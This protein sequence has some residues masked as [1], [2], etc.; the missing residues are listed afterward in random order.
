MEGIGGKKDC[1]W[2]ECENETKLMAGGRKKN[3]KSIR[4]LQKE[5]MR[6][7][8]TGKKEFK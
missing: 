1:D 8:T 5:V 2:T 7:D 3:P 6:M 4:C